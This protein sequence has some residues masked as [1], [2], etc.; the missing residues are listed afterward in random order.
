MRTRK[1][2]LLIAA[3]A[4]ALPA[5][6]PA[7]AQEGGGSARG[8][9]KIEDQDLG[10]ADTPNEV[11]VGCAFRID[12]F[13]FEADTV[14]VRLSL[15]PPSGDAALVERSAELQDAQGNELSGSLLVDLTDELAGVE[16]AKAEDFDYKVRV[17]VVVKETPGTEVTKSSMLFIDCEDAAET[18]RTEV[19]A[20]AESAQVGSAP[21]TEVAAVE[22]DQPLG[23]AAGSAGLAEDRMPGWALMLMAVG[24]L[25]LAG[26]GLRKT[27]QD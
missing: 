14:P 5:A 4:V 24:A 3:M 15:Q 26:T 10:P 21:R 11:K 23:V 7:F 16:P 17:E 13:G 25:T 20:A 8:S 2:Q 22:V 18:F 6:A 12:F 19:A 9:V 27:V 1:L